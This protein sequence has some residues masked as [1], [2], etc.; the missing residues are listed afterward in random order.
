MRTWYQFGFAAVAITAALAATPAQASLIAD[1]ITYTLTESTTGNPLTDQFVLGI[2]G[3]NGAADTEG[4]RSGV[5]ALAFTQP[6]NY[7]T[8]VMIDP[9]T[10]FVLINGGLA[11]T[12]C[13]TTGNFFCFDNTA[14]PPTPATAFPADSTLSYTF[15]VTLS[16]GSFAGYVPS[17]KIDWVGSQNNYD[18]VSLPLTPTPPPSVPE[19]A[20]LALLGSALFG[21]GLVRRRK[22]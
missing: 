2:S 3:I 12:G 7:S 20:T 10:G 8:A 11:S 17:F 22:S 1:G 15:D 6:S 4:G 9:A 13:N 21:L 18:L 19:P 14:I 16:S 5:N